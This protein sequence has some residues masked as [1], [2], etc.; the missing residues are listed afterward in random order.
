MRSVTT[1][2]WQ[3]ALTRWADPV[4]GLALLL[5]DERTAAEQRTVAVLARNLVGDPAMLEARLFM[6]LVRSDRWQRLQLRSL[7]PARLRHHVL[8]PALV[9]VRPVDRVLLGLW[10]LHDVDG[11]RLAQAAGMEV[12]ALVWRLAA[13]LA[14]LTGH[15]SLQAA[16]PAFETWLGRQLQVPGAERPSVAEQSVLRSAESTAWLTAIE[17]AR[18]TLRAAVGQHHVPLH[19]LDAVAAEILE[20][21][22]APAWWQQRAVW[23]AALIGGV[24]LLL[25]YLI[26]PW[27]SRATA[28][29]AAQAAPRA[30]V[31]QALDAW[32][33]AP[34]SGAVHRRVWARS[35]T[36]AADEPLVTDVWLAARSAQHRVEVRH[37][38]TLVEW[39]LGDGRSR[40]EYAAQPRFSSCQWAEPTMLDQLIRA[41]T[42]PPAEQETVRNAR[43]TLG[44]Y[45]QGYQL[46]HQALAADDLRSY[47]RRTEDDTTLL[48]LGFTDRQASNERQIILWIEPH[49][50]TLHVVQELVDAGGA[51]A[52][53][54]LWRLLGEDNPQTGVPMQQP[55]WDRSMQARELLDPAC[56][57][58]DADHVLSL[59]TLFGWSF[60]W[61]Q[62]Y[63]PSEPPPGSTQAALLTVGRVS[64]LINSSGNIRAVFVG[65]GRRLSFTTLPQRSELRK[66]GVRRDKWQVVFDDHAA[67]LS[68]TACLARESVGLC[69]P[70][71]RFAARGWSR[72]ELLATI[73]TLK[74]LDETMWLAYDRMFLEPRPL[75]P[76]IKAAFEGTIR[77]QQP[78]RR[79]QLF[80]T[81]VE[82]R[83]RVNPHRPSLH[84]PYHVP[85]DMLEPEHLT[86]EQW[87]VYSDTTVAQYKDLYTLPSGDVYSA[88]VNNGVHLSE[89]YLHE[90]VARINRN[91]PDAWWIEPPLTPA[92]QL[93]RTYLAS[94][95]PITARES[96]NALL[97]EQYVPTEDGSHTPAMAG[98]LVPWAGDLP[99]GVTVRRIWFD[100]KTHLPQRAATVYVDADSRETLLTSMTLREWRYGDAAAA[101]LSLPPLPPDIIQINS[102]AGSSSITGGELERGAITRALVWPMDSEIV[103]E[104]D[105]NPASF[106]PAARMGSDPRLERALYTPI[107]MLESLNLIKV[108]TYKLPTQDLRVTIRQGPRGLLRHVLRH[109]EL[110]NGTLSLP[111]SASREVPVSIAGQQYTAWLLEDSPTA[112]LVVEV[113]EVLLYIKGP[114]T[115]TLSAELPAELAKL[116]WVEILH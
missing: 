37:G 40:F 76:D 88:R 99:P 80:H 101:E 55:E 11:L 109:T 114:S 38:N 105:E 85:V 34:P 67:D 68:G 104:Q 84:D 86:Q 14:T 23:L 69:M 106:D 108:T 8:P 3:A 71:L 95:M 53:R 27:Q 45:G 73:A 49:T 17:T 74:P 94:T 61:G 65:P 22:D 33:A 62:D 31:Q 36:N 35:V 93:V 89:Y 5:A 72:D 16:R 13:A 43:L 100:P 115:A 57:G 26:A 52:S 12:A 63:L 110:D 77:A 60:G 42:L 6:D 97:L 25:L 50:G 103:V 30:I 92:M 78:P 116:E 75:A 56:P 58:L 113:D 91:P 24:G 98:P 70:L 47:G 9:R 39:Q 41:F 79:N 51:N 2:P 1:Q 21:G 54:E 64:D 19:C 15:P 90:G 102:T 81:L 112:A 29:T 20:Q 66:E 10:L 82:W 111:R 59:R 96:E 28:T 83:A 18:A 48:A 7:L 32:S 4:F 46:L 87:L 44:A 107:H